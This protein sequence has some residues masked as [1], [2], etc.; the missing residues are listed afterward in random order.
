[1]ELVKD[2][3][4]WCMVLNFGMFFLYFAIMRFGHDRVYRN[5]SRWYPMSVEK[6][7]A[8]HYGV[9]QAYKSFIMFFNV[10]PWIALQLISV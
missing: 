1:M 2:F 9:S 4:F 5:H 7:D 6:F 8:I 3:L 10:V